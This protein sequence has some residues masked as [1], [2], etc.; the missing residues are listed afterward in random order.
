[1]LK[2]S[3]CAAA[4]CAL[5]VNA[6]AGSESKNGISARDLEPTCGTPHKNLLP[7]GLGQSYYVG[8]PLDIKS[9]FGNVSIQQHVSSLSSSDYSWK[10]SNTSTWI[11]GSGDGALQTRSLNRMQLTKSF[12]Y[13]N[14]KADFNLSKASEYSEFLEKDLRFG[15]TVSNAKP[16]SLCDKRL[17]LWFGA[18][19]VPDLGNAGVVPFINFSYKL[20]ENHFVNLIGTRLE[21][22][23]M[24][25]DAKCSVFVSYNGATWDV[26]SATQADRL[27]VYRS[28]F[29]GVG[30][31]RELCCGLNAGVSAGYSFANKLHEYNAAGNRKLEGSAL[32]DGFGLRLDLLLKF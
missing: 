32:G 28:W 27:L 30:Y 6:M 8:S 5:G 3:L 31:N 1:M 19:L 20:A 10:L 25:G 23:H 18:T 7:D 9:G 11:D 2:Y 26:D 16:L 17:K 24:R 15:F 12:E 14:V 13:R 21:Y 29:A 22:A 4:L